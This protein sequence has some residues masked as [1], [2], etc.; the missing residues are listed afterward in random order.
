M[1]Q[2]RYFIVLILALVSCLWINV[3]HHAQINK[4]WIKA[5]Q[6]FSDMKSQL[7]SLKGGCPG[8]MM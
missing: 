8:G 1:N 3:F 6:S 7:E 4:E 5:N 2:T